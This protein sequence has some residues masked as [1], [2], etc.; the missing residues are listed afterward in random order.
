MSEGRKRKKEKVCNVDFIFCCFIFFL[1]GEVFDILI[2][3]LFIGY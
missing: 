1:L 2:L 3:L